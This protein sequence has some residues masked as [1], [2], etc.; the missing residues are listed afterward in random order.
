MYS[1]T[2]IYGFPDP[3]QKTENEKGY[4][5]SVQNTSTLSFIIQMI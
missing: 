5:I 3:T 2:A 1:K 4:C